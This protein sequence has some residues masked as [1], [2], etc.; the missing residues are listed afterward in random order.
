MEMMEDKEVIREAWERVDSMVTDEDN[1]YV[2]DL[3]KE[4]LRN[5]AISKLQEEEMEKYPVYHF[6]VIGDIHGYSERMDAYQELFERLRCADLTS[7]QVISID[8]PFWEGDL[9]E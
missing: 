8:G 9:N 7:L 1:D 6:E 2:V 5:V 4:T 3:F